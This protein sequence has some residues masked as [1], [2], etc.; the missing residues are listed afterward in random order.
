MG[1][2]DQVWKG[3][4]LS[5]KA[6]LPDR[7][8]ACGMIAFLGWMASE[9]LAS[10]FWS[11]GR[12]FDAALTSS[13]VLGAIGIGINLADRSTGPT[14]KHQV[15]RTLAGFLIGGMAGAISGSL[16]NL[17]APSLR[18]TWLIGWGL[19]GLGV[20]SVEGLYERSP[21]KLRIGLVGG[22]AGGLVGGVLFERVYWLLSP[23]SI[24]ASRAVGFVILG[25]CLGRLIELAS[26]IF[27]P[28]W[29]TVLDGDR[30]GRRLTLSGSTA[31]LGRA[32]SAAMSF[33]SRGNHTVD[34][35]HA[36]IVRLGNGRFALEDNHSRHGTTVNFARVLEQI[37]L[38]DG[39][40]IRIGPNSIRFN[41]RRRKTDGAANSPKD[42]VTA[43]S[44]VLASEAST[45]PPS[46]PV[47]G[48]SVVR[49]K[50][51]ATTKPPQPLVVT[52]TI[53]ADPL[54]SGMT[55]CPK[56]RRLVTGAR[57]FCIHCKLAF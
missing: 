6:W 46:Q 14:W 23:W 16:G 53:S 54:P 1:V 43:P 18:G 5:R 20:G 12:W 4:W 51:A 2:F 40:L 17:L 28:A 52:P 45:I 29:L 42:V 41:E 34:L 44:P 33:Q 31:L 19:M 27:C 9:I 13:L 55:R 8:L 22:L 3:G 49:L 38:K 56:C 48:S 7:M 39:D 37:V 47:P 11:E 57:P 36:Q 21:A 32:E 35:E 50:P 25:L 15:E 26:T 10:R 30:P 24:A